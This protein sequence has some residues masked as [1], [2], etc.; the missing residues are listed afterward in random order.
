MSI[1][2][3]LKYARRKKKLV[4]TTTSFQKLIYPCLFNKY[5]SC[6]FTNTIAVRLELT[7]FCV[8]YALLYHLGYSP[9]RVVL[10]R[11]KRLK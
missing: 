2:P 8:S 10:I 3:P 1:D 4:E 7:S 5:F 6:F 11:E 9:V